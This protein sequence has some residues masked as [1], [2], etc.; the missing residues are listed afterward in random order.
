MPLTLDK[1]GQFTFPVVFFFFFFFF[2]LFNKFDAKYAAL[3]FNTVT[4]NGV[5]GCTSTDLGFT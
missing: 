4:L 5:Q 2:Q 3:K 1:P